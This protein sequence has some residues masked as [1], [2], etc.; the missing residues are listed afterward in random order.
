VGS[1]GAIGAIGENSGAEEWAEEAG[2]LVLTRAEA[3]EQKYLL[4]PGRQAMETSFS[5]LWYKFMDRVFSRSWRG[6]GN[7]I[8]LKV[9]HYHLCQAGVLSA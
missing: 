3:P 9:L 4:A 2:L 7:T 6:L 5:P 8:P 1:R